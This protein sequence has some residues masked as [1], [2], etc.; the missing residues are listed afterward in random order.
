MTDG[1]LSADELTRA[2]ALAGQVLA[3]DT[4]RLPP[5]MGVADGPAE[6]LTGWSNGKELHTDTAVRLDPDLSTRSPDRSRI[7]AI[8]TFVA[9]VSGAVTARGHTYSPTSLAL[10]TEPTRPGDVMPPWPGP[11]LDGFGGPIDSPPTGVRCGLLHDLPSTLLPNLLGTDRGR[12]WSTSHG[13]YEVLVRA[14][15][16]HETTCQQAFSV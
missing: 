8:N 3:S 7:N 15:L 12:V 2:R 11:P 4:I 16:P 13:P 6:R 14:L 10:F 5:N 9:L 1:M